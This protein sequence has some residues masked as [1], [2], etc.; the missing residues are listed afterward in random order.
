MNAA[1]K[2]PF[3]RVFIKGQK[4]RWGSCSKQRNL[5]FNWRLVMA[6]LP[7]I[8]YVVAHELAHLVEMNHSRK[9][10][11]LVEQIYPGYS[12]HRAWLKE[13]GRLLTL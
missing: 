8:D 6:P 4:T 10:W 13:N 12:L 9:F 3:N 11:A 5:S 2:Q 7:V 1:F